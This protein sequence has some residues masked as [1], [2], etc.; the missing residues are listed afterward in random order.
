[1]AAVIIGLAGFLLW[2]LQRENNS[3]LIVSPS[4]SFGVVYLPVT[5]A[6]SAYYRLG[7][8]SGALVTGVDRG[9]ALDLAGVKAGDVILSFNGARVEDGKPLLG[10][11]RACPMGSC[12]T[13]DVWNGNG[14]RQVQV[15]LAAR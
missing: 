6:L 8:T 3:V 10:M 12:V 15:A 1:M 11:I 14:V 4:A 2:R 9:S 7:V 13:L 5:K